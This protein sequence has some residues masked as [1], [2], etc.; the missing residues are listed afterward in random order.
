MTAV[1]DM[2]A[3]VEELRGRETRFVADAAHEL[4][5]PVT[6]LSLQVDRLSDMPMSEQAQQQRISERVS[7]VS[8]TSSVSC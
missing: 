7:R 8:L 4:R 2:F 3:R 6:A 1:N 5:S